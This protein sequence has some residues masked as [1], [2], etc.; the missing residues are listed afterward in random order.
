MYVPVQSGSC[1]SVHVVVCCCVT[2]LF[3]V[4]FCTFILRPLVFLFNW[5]TSV[6]SDLL[7]LKAV[8]WPVVINFCIIWFL[9]KSWH[10]GNNTTSPFLYHLLVYI[11]TKLI[12][13]YYDKTCLYQ[14]PKEAFS[15][16]NADNLWHSL[17]YCHFI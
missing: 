5:F 2:Y 17:E 1:N 11:S 16:R 7:L 10:I 6:I 4:Y 3:F 13:M 12:I 14:P 9:V 8:L 15:S